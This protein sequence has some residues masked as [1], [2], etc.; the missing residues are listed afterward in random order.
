M[1]EVPGERLVTAP[2]PTT[3]VATKVLL[4]LQV[5]PVAA[6]VKLAVLP[7]HILVLPAMPAGDGFTVIISDLT[8]PVLVNL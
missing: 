3:T 5:P 7:R 8:Q 2:V 6:S 1:V 4:L